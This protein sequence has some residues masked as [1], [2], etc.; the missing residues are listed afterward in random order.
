MRL[1]SPRA[2]LRSAVDERL[3]RI[4]LLNQYYAPDEAATA[5]ML[6]D[7]GAHLASAGHDVRAI[8]CDRSYSQPQRRYGR[9]ETIDGVRIER[10]PTTAFGRSSPIGRL[11]DYV[12]FLIGAAW[13]LIAGRKA[14]V[15]VA[16]T[17][18]PIIAFVPIMLRPWL[19]FKVVFWSMDVYPELAFRLG[20]LRR[21][22]LFGRLFAAL[23]HRV[24]SGSDVIVSL[25]ETMAITL[26]QLGGRNVE[27][28]HNWADERAIVPCASNASPSRSEWGWERRFVAV[29]SGNL[30]LAH[31]FETLVAAAKQLSV[32]LPDVLVAFVGNGPRLREVQEATKN[33][34][35]VEFRDFVE[36]SRLGDSLAAADVHLVTLRSDMAGLLVPSKIYGILAAGRPTIYVGPPAGEVHDI[37]RDGRCG[38]SIR[39]GDVDRLV[40]AIRDYAGDRSRLDREGE[41]ARRYFVQHFTKEGRLTALREIIERTI[42]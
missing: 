3:V 39:N 20:A 37:L 30:G 5:Q 40:A 17:T 2:R 11:A 21:G 38:V 8:C 13:R 25:G 18:P 36:R 31:E 26:R 24:L 32:A 15:V 34:P 23:S 6:S 22:S 7:L 14:D 12:G 19:R 9:R 33:L 41:S 16:L 29:Y 27:V 42:R 1:C 10:V 35:N 28:V 4:A